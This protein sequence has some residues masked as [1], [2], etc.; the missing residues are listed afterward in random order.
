MKCNSYSHVIR[1]E[2]HFH[3]ELQVHVNQQTYLS[4]Y[5][6]QLTLERIG[7]LTIDAVQIHLQWIPNLVEREGNENADTLTKAE[8]CEAPELSA[9][10]TLLEFFSKIKHQNKTA[11]IISQSTIGISVLGLEAFWLEPAA[12]A[13]VF[14]CLRLTKQDLADH[15]LLMLD[16]FRVYDV[17]E[18]VEYCWPM[19]TCNNNSTS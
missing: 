17:M 9:P 8:A 15:P 19:G 14:E 3:S 1:N 16:F 5:L 6:K 18:L 11:W 10:L 7:E 12:P 13:H 2:E 4:A